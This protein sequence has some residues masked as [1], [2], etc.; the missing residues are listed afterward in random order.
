MIYF[1]TNLINQMYQKTDY[2]PKRWL[3]N[4]LN[5]IEKDI[6]F[7]REQIRISLIQSEWKMPMQ[8][9]LEVLLPQFIS[10]NRKPSSVP[11]LKP[12]TFFKRKLENSLKVYLNEILKNH[13][14]KHDMAIIL[15]RACLD[16]QTPEFYTL[17]LTTGYIIYGNGEPTFGNLLC[18]AHELGHALYELDFPGDELGSEVSAFQVEDHV[19][20]LLLK[21]L[22]DNA[23]WA[24]Y[25]F[26]QDQLN[27]FLC[28]NECKEFETGIS[29]TL[30]HH[31]F[32]RESLVTC[33]GYQC[34]NAWASVKRLNT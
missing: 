22:N 7:Y 19:A 17:P 29:K 3:Q 10:A 26:E 8:A 24:Q 18:L 14:R 4:N 2:A 27:Y 23:E 31:L 13:S 9:E 11:T 16:L 28:L 34:I 1:T 32:F 33:W 15:E 12:P 20:Q 6:L 30:Q 25:K 5:K 21:D